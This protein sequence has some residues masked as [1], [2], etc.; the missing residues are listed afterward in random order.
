MGKKIVGI[1]LALVFCV[2]M[3]GNA[4]AIEMNG[5]NDGVV[6]STIPTE[7]DLRLMDR[8]Q[9]DET[10]KAWIIDSEGNKTEVDPVDM[11]NPNSRSFIE[12]RFEYTFV[13]YDQSVTKSNDYQHFVSSCSFRNRGTE[14][15]P[16]QYTQTT[17]VRND[18]SVTGKIDVEAE[19]KLAVLKSLQ[20]KFGASVCDVHS[21]E[22]SE[23]V[24]FTLSVPVGKTGKISK[25]YAGKYSGGQGVWL[26]EDIVSGSSAGYYYEEATAWGIATNEVNYDW[27]VT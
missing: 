3:C 12:G 14:A 24:E 27:T 8:G 2:S 19:F 11:A 6:F 20:A 5:T 22:E 16:L 9:E 7:N 18:W 10:V 23:K 1:F 17:T 4:S 15:V 21:T 26:M 25:Y 13:R